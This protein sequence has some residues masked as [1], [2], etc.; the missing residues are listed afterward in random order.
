MKQR[1]FICK[2]CGNLIALAQGEAHL[3]LF[4]GMQLLALVA[5]LRLNGD[6]F[7]VV[8]RQHGMLHLAHLDMNGAPLDGIDG[9]VLRPVRGR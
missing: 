8:L 5:L 2:H 9:D 4:A 7:D 1:F 6:P 3:R